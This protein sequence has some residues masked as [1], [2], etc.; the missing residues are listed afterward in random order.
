MHRPSLVLVCILG[1]V[2]I[3]FWWFRSSSLHNA[4][5][6]KMT[7]NLG[8]P[9]QYHGKLN[10]TH[11]T[12]YCYQLFTFQFSPPLS[13]D[14][15]GKTQ[16]LLIGSLVITDA[17]GKKLLDWPLEQHLAHVWNTNELQ[18]RHWGPK[19]PRGT[20]NV[21]VTVTTPSPGLASHQ[22]LLVSEY[23]Q[24]SPMED[25]WTPVLFLIGCVLIIY[26]L[27]NLILFGTRRPVKPMF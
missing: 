19:I 18:A 5:P 8:V 21:A 11:D 15:V 23:V 25:I 13:A 16:D 24:C 27:G 9:D 20:Y 1:C 22:Q 7:V 4:R 10:Q 6:I 17:T 12:R 14:E 26:G 2:L 3:A